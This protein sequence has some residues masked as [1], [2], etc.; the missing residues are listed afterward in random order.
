[1]LEIIAA[2]VA[3]PPPQNGCSGRGVETAGMAGVVAEARLQADPGYLF[4]RPMPVDDFIAWWRDHQG[5][6]RRFGPAAGA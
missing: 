3:W 6:S 2:I 4:A 5:P 1:M